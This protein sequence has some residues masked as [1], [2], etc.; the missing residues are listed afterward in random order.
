MRETVTISEDGGDRS[1]RRGSS[2]TVLFDAALDAPGCLI[3][4]EEFPY[5]MEPVWVVGLQTGG[6]GNQERGWA[7][8]RNFPIALVGEYN[9][10]GPTVGRCNAIE[11][12]GCYDLDWARTLIDPVVLRDYIVN[13]YVVS[14]TRWYP[15]LWIRLKPQ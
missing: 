11:F 14:G 13:G 9:A 5:N 4:D 3:D 6:A 7:D 12:I 1:E 2:E 10:T 8:F 15:P